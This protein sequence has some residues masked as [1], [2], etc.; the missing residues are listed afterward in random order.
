[1]LQRCAQYFKLLFFVRLQDH[2]RRSCWRLA[3]L[4]VWP[5]HVP[6]LGP[7]YLGISWASVS[8]LPNEFWKYG[9]FTLNPHEPALV[10]RILD[11]NKMKALKPDK[12]IYKY[13]VSK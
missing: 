13:A 10:M 4:V 8:Q 7:P 12:L 1:M 2:L 6:V 3:R 9:V 11:G 5:C